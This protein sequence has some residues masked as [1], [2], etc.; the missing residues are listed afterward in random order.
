M[1]YLRI[2]RPSDWQVITKYQHPDLDQD[3]A[4]KLIYAYSTS[5]Y[6]GRFHKLSAIADNAQIV[7][8]VSMIEQDDGVVSIGVEVYE[9]FRRKGYAYAGVSQMLTYANAMNYRTATA[10]VRKDNVASLALCKKLGF[11]VSGESI[12]SRGN[13]VYN[14]TKSV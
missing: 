3:G 14:L 12:S 13:P 7:G 6:Q 5:N 11:S 10:Q 4:I 1:I 8:Y 2:F 9:P